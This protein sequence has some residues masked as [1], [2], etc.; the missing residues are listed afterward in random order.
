MVVGA[1]TVRAGESR[2]DIVGA[3]KVLPVGCHIRANGIGLVPLKQQAVFHMR[4]AQLAAEQGSDNL[5]E[6]LLLGHAA[7]ALYQHTLAV[8]N[9]PFLFQ[10]AVRGVAGGG[11]VNAVLLRNLPKQNVA[12]IFRKI[13]IIEIDL[14]PFQWLFC[15][16]EPVLIGQA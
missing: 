13:I 3:D 14:A 6:R 9:L 5:V 7:T 2:K 16:I 4:D 10:P 12:D 8:Q 15:R 1:H 11:K